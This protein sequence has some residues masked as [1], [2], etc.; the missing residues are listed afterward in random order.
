MFEG[1]TRGIGFVHSP[2]LK[3]SG[4]ETRYCSTYTTNQILFFLMNF[5]KRTLKNPHKFDQYCWVFH[6]FLKTKIP[7]QYSQSLISSVIV[8]VLYYRSLMHAVDWLPTLMT[9]IG[10]PIPADLS[11]VDQWEA[12]NSRYTSRVNW[13]HLMESQ[14][15]LQS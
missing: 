5:V 15:Y 7:T 2:L 14:V 12:I 3:Q 1:G 10:Q 9:A 8:F 4:F 13:C 11:G 6:D